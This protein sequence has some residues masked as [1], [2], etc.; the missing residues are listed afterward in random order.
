[1]MSIKYIIHLVHRVV[2]N[3]NGNMNFSLKNAIYL[4]SNED[5]G[6]LKLLEKLLLTNYYLL[7][8]GLDAS[9]WYVFIVIN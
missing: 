3:A 9:R 1:M 4:A 6:E 7:Y 8:N 2:G 5:R